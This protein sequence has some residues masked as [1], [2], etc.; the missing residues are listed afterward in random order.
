LTFLGVAF[1]P[2]VVVP[3]VFATLYGPWVGGIGAAIGIFI[4]DM[5]FHGNA[6]LSLIAGVPANFLVF[7]M[8]GYF[9]SKEFTFRKTMISLL[10]AAV[11]LCISLIAPV[12][13]LPAEFAAY[14]TNFSS[15]VALVG[16]VATVVACMGAIAVVGFK[17]RQWSSYVVGSVVAQAIG[18]ALL[19]VTVWAVSPLFLSYFGKPIPVEWI[20]PI[21]VWTFATE[22][23]FVLVLGPPIIKASYRA[24]PNLRKRTENKAT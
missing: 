2:A 9:A 17:W 11:V 16:F 14:P 20:L 12:T 21:F 7:F 15:M 10:F 4:R 23:P 13:L 8:I 18:A 24:F 22:I 5:L 1:F 6:A 3:A 19:S